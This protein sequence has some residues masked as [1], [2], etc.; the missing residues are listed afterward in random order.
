[1]TKPQKQQIGEFVLNNDATYDWTVY[2]EIPGKGGTRV[3]VKIGATFKHVTPE[4]RV[5]VLEEYRNLVKERA[6]KRDRDEPNDDQDSNEGNDDIE[7]V[8]QA[9]GFE[10]SLLNEVLIGF[11]YVRDVHGNAVTYLGWMID[12]GTPIPLLGADAD[13][14]VQAT[15]PVGA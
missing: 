4:R 1:M 8:R 12:C 14:L 7:A 10:G 15:R 11:K 6:K 9:L 3:K 5:A 2:P 13:W